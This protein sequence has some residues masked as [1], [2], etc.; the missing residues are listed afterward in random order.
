TLQLKDSGGTANGGVDTSA[1]RTFAISVSPVNDAPNAPNGAATTSENAATSVDLKLFASDLETATSSLTY[2]IVAGPSNGTLSSGS[3]GVF[4]FT[5]QHNYNGTDSFTYQVTDT[6][7]PAGCTGTAPACDAPKTSSTG[8]I[9]LAV[10]PVNDAPVASDGS[11]TTNEDTAKAV[12]LSALASDTETPSGSLTYSI[13]AG[14]GHGTVVVSAAGIATYTPAANYNGSDAFTYRVTDSGDPAGCVGTGPSC[15][16]AKTSAT[17]QVSLTVNPV[18]DRPVAHDLAVDVPASNVASFA[19]S[20][21]T[22]A[23]GSALVADV[24]TSNANLS[25]ALVSAPSKGTLTAGSTPGSFTYQAAPLATGTDTATYT[26]TDRGDPDNCGTLSA[27]CDG[28][29]TSTIHTITFALPATNAPPVTSGLELW[30]DA[31]SV[32]QADGQ[33]VSAWSDAS[34]FGRDLTAA[35]GA[36]ASMR[37]NAVNGHAAIDF[38]GVS[39]LFKSYGSTF[40]IAQP[41]TFFIVY[42]AL[43]PSTGARAFVF[44]STDSA[45][46]QVFGRSAQYANRM[47]ANQDFDA[48]G[49]SF[50]YPNFQIWSGT[51]NGANS[52]MYQNGSLV[53][54]GNAGTSNLA[55]LA[56][57]GLSTDG[58]NGY[59]RGHSQIANLL[60]YSGALTDAQRQSITEWLNQKYGVIGLASGPVNTTAPSIS[61]RPVAGQT[62][63]AASGAWLGTPPIS[64]SYETQ[65][66]DTAGANC[67]AVGTGPS[68]TVGT[69]DIGS[70]I[71]LAVTATNGVG[72]AI[73]VSPPSVVV[74]PA[75]NLNGDA[76]PVT[77]GLEMWFD[78]SHETYANGASV[79]RWSDLSGAGRDLTPGFPDQAPTFRA[80]AF[81]GQPA[82]E[83]DGV[84]SVMKTFG[85]TFT[86]AQPD[87]YFIVYQQLD[88][89]QEAYIFDSANSSQRQLLGRAPAGDLEMYANAALTVANPP[90][91]FPGLQL[92]SGTYNGSSSDLYKNGTLIAHGNT[93]LG[94]L[95]GL[96]V[97]ALSSSA[98]YGYNYSHSLV[99]A[100]LW[101]SGTLTDAQRQAVTT[102]LNN[103]YQFVQK[104]TATVTAPAQVTSGTAFT[105]SLDNGQGSSSPLHY[106]FSCDGSPLDAVT[107]ATGSTSSSTTC[108]FTTGTPTR[109]LLARVIASD[110]QYTQYSVT[111][112]VVDPPTAT[113]TAPDS[114]VEGSSIHVSLDGATST[115]Q[116]ARDAGFTFAFDCG[117]GSGYGAFG[118]A[119]AVDCPTS[120]NGSVTVRARVRDTF[121]NSTEY[122]KAITVQNAPPVVT[123]PGAQSASEA[124]PGL[125]SLG[126]FADAGVNDGPWHVVIGWGDTTSSVFDA[127]VAGDLGTLTHTY[128]D[129]GT[130]HVTVTVTDKDAGSGSQTFDVAVANVAP[131]AS[132][133][134]TSP[135][136]EGSA[137][138]L[139]LT[140]ASD[141]S[142]VDTAA[143]F[144]RT[145]SCDGTTYTATASCT[146]ND[147]GSFTVYGRIADKDGGATTYSA[148]VT[149]TN[150]APTATFAAASPVAEGSP[151]ALSLTGASDPS[152]V[153]TA[154]GFTRTYS[155]DGTTSS[156][157]ASCTFND[158]G[159][160]TVYGKIA[161]KDG[162]TSSYS[163]S[164]TV[165]NVAPTATFAATSPVNEGSAT[166]LS[167]T[168]ASDP[169]S[170]DTAAGFT[171]TYSCDGT[172]YTATASCT[173]NDNGTYTVYGKIADKNGGT[174]SYSA[175]V[176]VTN[177]A[178]SLT[179]PAAQTASEGSAALLPLGSFTDPGTADQPWHVVVAWGDA[180]SSAFNVT[181]SGSLG[182]LTHTY[183]D[184]GAF[185]VSV[186]ITDKDN[187]TGTASFV[188]TVANV[189]PTA[190]FGYSTPVSEGSASTLS[191]TSPSDPSSADTAA[192]F[193]RTYSC[194]GSSY[195]AT[196]SCSFTDNGTYTVYGRIADKDGGASTYSASVTV[197]NV[198]P[199]ATFAATSPV[200]EGS[201]TALSLTGASDPSSAD[202]AAGFTRTY[203]CDGT[204]Y[205]AT[206]SC[207]FNDNGTKTVYGRIADKNGG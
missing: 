12:D 50:P 115:S 39:S 79:T 204:T 113:L 202:T 129:S 108:S 68:Y 82:L 62:L 184:S 63:T 126:S 151:T 112:N 177:V 140:G 176:T 85:S 26:V 41:D 160:Y 35:P 190:T 65:R 178:P 5:P 88:S 21:A 167:L 139:S 185:T 147:N 182:T 91:P 23:D 123:A 168:G 131:T 76:P 66:C 125:V 106:A 169:S 164:V 86:L 152:S 170:V 157:T 83:F 104:P 175:P 145:Y 75:P 171:R 4:T 141:P 146:F 134:A 18:N 130:Y 114:V 6:G 194:D 191:L 195:S 118:T 17:K 34:G 163:A 156:A 93:G 203:S 11:A 107:Y 42:R 128:G 137:S 70:T 99:S 48:Q 32:G 57:G 53:L 1:S 52:T 10:N 54:A 37:L 19:L 161:D 158:N 136:S 92:W 44:D 45:N 64:Y 7:D 148:S 100:I 96:T 132:F 154:A 24:E 150:V 94:P 58:A 80:N 196:A 40:T 103:R 33:P 36:A 199:T 73:A 121:G 116:Q 117:N 13:V 138:A 89:S 101:Y 133:A 84:R 3:G 43:D 25:Y 110:D 51:F 71:R 187:G 181:A 207:T 16:G 186:T 30:F 78:A 162:G 206:A 14:A 173:F 46:R 77:A 183:V 201:P 67:V 31:D 180:T 61:G 189:A 205:T 59:D 49:V 172:T 165:T 166:T 29:A 97:G 142:S 28:A 127:A 72:S 144:T 124:S 2:T 159:S 102:W 87:T 38:N 197:T 60:V 56:L 27:T 8:T 90:F 81:N 47:Y 98:Q 188:V 120:D 179:A 74:T 155:C 105:F 122:T 198:A 135:V 153:D 149:V 9:S 109:T 192:G 111:V 119:S 55:G 95:S 143:G 200:A 69:G 22:N 20:T 193:T 15:D 174:S